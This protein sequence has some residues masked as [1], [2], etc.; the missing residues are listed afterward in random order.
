MMLIATTFAKGQELYTRS[1]GD[2]SNPPVIFLHGGP[3]FNCVNFEVTTAEK[4]AEKGFHVIVYDRRGEGRSTKENALY[5]FEQT[6]NDLNLI[7]DKYGITTATLIGHS[8]G[9]MLT[10]LF[11]EKFAD[12]VN[13]IVLLSTP[14]SLQKTYENIISRVKAI[15]RNNNDSENMRYVEMLESMDKTSLEYNSFCLMHAM[16]NGFYTPKQPSDEVKQMYESV[17]SSAEMKSVPPQQAYGAPAGFWWNE[18]YTVL[19]IT[20]N[21]SR[22]K[23]KRIPIMAIY[24]TDDGLFSDSQIADM[25]SLLGKDNVLCLEN[26][27]HNVFI[28]RQQAFIDIVAIR[29]KLK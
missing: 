12:K 20:E 10:A 19:D 6:F 27:S 21:I 5:T 15:Y 16:S 29:C 24:G 26:C 23:A 25:E 14:L 22:L 7:Y 3:G 9:G 13:G 11:A 17:K 4:L 28:D 18:K 1:F 2:A 8:F